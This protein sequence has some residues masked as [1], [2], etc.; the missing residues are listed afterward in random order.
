[1]AW[2]VTIA[3]GTAADGEPIPVEVML[4]QAGTR[5]LHRNV[6]LGATPS[7]SDMAQVR[8]YL[9]D[10]PTHPF[11]PAPILAAA[12]ARRI[13]Q[14]G[15]ALFESLCDS[16]ADPRLAQALGADLETT[17][18]EILGTSGRV[19]W[20]FLR[21]PETGR[22]P[23][24]HAQRLVRVVTGPPRPAA[25]VNHETRML[26]VISRP[27]ST[28]DVGFQSVARPLLSTL[29]T[30][31]AFDVTVLRPP[32]HEA[33]HESLAT[34]AAQGRPFELVHFDGHGM[35]QDGSGMFL[36]EGR[37][38]GDPPDLVPGSELG[39]DLAAAGVRIAVLNACRSADVGPP[40]PEALR[41]LAEELVNAGLSGA[42]AMQYNVRVGTAARLVVPLYAALAAGMSVG[43]SVTDARRALHHAMRASRERGAVQTID[44]WCVPVA[45]QAQQVAEPQR[46]APRIAGPGRAAIYDPAFHGRDDVLLRIDRGFAQCPTIVITGMAGSGKTA[47][48]RQFARWFEATGGVSGEVVE[49]GIGRYLGQPGEVVLDALGGSVEA[50]LANPPALLIVDGLDAPAPEERD[51]LNDI[52]ARLTAAGT[53]ILVTANGAFWITGAEEVRLGGLTDGDMVDVLVDQLMEAIDEAALAAWRPVIDLANGNPLALQTL[54]GWAGDTDQT[55]SALRALVDDVL[56]G[57]GPELPAAARESLELLAGY[58]LDAE[59]WLRLLVLLHRQRYADINQLLKMGQ[60]GLPEHLEELE[61]VGGMQ[62]AA[63]FTR[64]SVAGLMWPAHD[65]YFELHPLFPSV[66]AEAVADVRDPAR[67]ARIERTFAFLMHSI[68]WSIL[69][70]HQSGKNYERNLQWA[71]SEEHDLRH[72]L[73]LATR[74]R[75]W[76]IVNGPLKGLYVHYR[77]T[78]R[79]NEWSMLVRSAAEHAVAPDGAAMPERE[80]LWADVAPWLQDIAMTDRD[81]AEARKWGERLVAYWRSC[82]NS[83]NLALALI[84][85][86]MA[87]RELDDPECLSQLEE[88]KGLLDE[89]DE[90]ERPLLAAIHFHLGLSYQ[91]LLKHR[92]LPRATDEYGKSL[93][94]QPPQDDQRRAKCISQQAQVALQAA[95]ED[96][97]GPNAQSLTEAWQ[98]SMKALDRFPST[99]LDDHAVVR[100]RLG[101]IARVLGDCEAALSH[102]LAARD[103]LERMGDTSGQAR[104]R[105]N[106]ALDMQG[107]GRI[108]DALVYAIAAESVFASLGEAGQEGRSLAKSLCEELTAEKLSR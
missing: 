102:D 98:L 77:A 45:Y 100:E 74:R 52:F 1:M 88:A 104:S 31:A 30:R 72:A 92:D 40:G 10:F 63:L 33:L 78:G 36:F 4:D 22:L 76:D 20:E 61:G 94:L 60:P 28:A 16:V 49:V 106:V 55:P 14:I 56:G 95:L 51:L 9:E 89:E 79:R 39:A 90:S 103:F 25:Q 80:D 58:F 70:E 23:A 86:A 81:F 41:S 7:P 91:T 66:L 11:D 53:R 44:D 6:R 3:E 87:V 108:E 26:L 75:W 37:G 99:A 85:L 5:V 50:A 54:I 64:L 57:Q 69:E 82:D 24:V 15:N 12:A 68:G 8:W 48:A 34:A 83:H 47:T 17:S 93:E 2:T 18:I 62:W 59:D 84:N 71:Q 29:A 107:L 105:Y 65:A 101:R 27:A 67:V 73:E 19:P 96:P 42:V 21:N 46:I 35:L 38:R 13:E 43:D 32:T 97:N